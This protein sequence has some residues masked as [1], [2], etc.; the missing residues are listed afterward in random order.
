MKCN[1]YLKDNLYHAPQTKE[2]QAAQTETQ[3]IQSE[4]PTS[5]PTELRQAATKCQFEVLRKIAKARYDDMART[6]SRRS[7]SS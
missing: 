6:I 4:P 2:M 5:T 1:K 7:H 3:P